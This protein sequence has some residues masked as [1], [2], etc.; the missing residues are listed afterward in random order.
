M[1]DLLFDASS[2]VKA[3]KLG[4]VEL[5]YRSY[6]QWLTFYEVLNA[7]WKE[8]YLSKTIS[9]GRAVELARLLNRVTRFMRVLSV[10]GLEEEVLR[11]AIDLGLTAYDSS[12]VVL[13]QKFDLKLVTEDEEL[14]AKARKLVKCASV[15]EL[16]ET[17]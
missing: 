2:L 7:V 12:Y 11:T 17:G 9:A 13:A 8:V 14:K 1:P 4:R 16:M 10:E 6:A 15:E 5:L 3:L